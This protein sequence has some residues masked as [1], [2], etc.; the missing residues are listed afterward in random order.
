MKRIGIFFG[1]KSR[2]R[3]ISFGSGR[4]VYDNIDKSK[5]IPIPIFVDGLG[6]FILLDWQYIY[7]G[8][9]LDFFPSSELS[10]TLNSSL[11]IE[12]YANDLNFVEKE[13]NKI[14]KKINQTIFQH[15]SIL[16]FL[17]CMA[18]LAKMALFSLCLSG[19]VYLILDLEF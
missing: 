1:G 7:K 16:L 9:I 18:N 4:T 19:M 12:S 2:E 10:D 6:N 5:Y 14:G 3:E 11:Y 8:S 13:I 17:P 15:I